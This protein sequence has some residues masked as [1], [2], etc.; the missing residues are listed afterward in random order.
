MADQVRISKTLSYWL[1]HRPDEAGLTLDTQGWADVDAVLAAL[2][3]ARL[4]GDID[5]L[6]AVVEQSDKQRF[7]LSPDLARVRARQGHSISVD[8]ALPPATPPAVL[9]HGTVERFIEAIMTEGLSKMRRHHVHLS[10]DLETARRVG[11]RRGHA[12]I[13]EINAAEM[14]AGGHVFHVTE[15]KVWLTEAVPPQFLHRL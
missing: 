2:T 7:E 5:A 10:P 13:L 4:P 6:L 15:N 11:A 12:I 14:H 1:R 3:A 9:Y 8:L